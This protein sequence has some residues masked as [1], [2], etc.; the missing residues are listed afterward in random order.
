[1][2]VHPPCRAKKQAK[3]AVTSGQKAG[4]KKSAHKRAIGKAV[5]HPARGKRP[6]M[7]GHAVKKRK[8]C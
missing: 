4:E 1:M 8:H 5:K 7:L 3:R 2:T 6:R